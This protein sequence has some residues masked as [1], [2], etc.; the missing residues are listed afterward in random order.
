MPNGPRIVFKDDRDSAVGRGAVLFWGHFLDGPRQIIIAAAQT[1]PAFVDNVML[2]SEGWRHVREARDLHR[3]LRAFDFSL[4][5]LAGVSGFSHRKIAGEAWATRMRAVL[6]PGYD[7]EVH[8][9][10]ENLHLHA[11]LDP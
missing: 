8:G 9:E 11:E 2:V 10:G 6:G 1:A 7:I 4:N 3:E 5:R